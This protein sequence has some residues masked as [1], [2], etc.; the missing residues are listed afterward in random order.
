MKL[1]KLS[2]EEIQKSYGPLTDSSKQGEFVSLSTNT[3]HKCRVHFYLRALKPGFKDDLNRIHTIYTVDTK[4][5]AEIDLTAP[6]IS[7]FITFDNRPDGNIFQF[8]IGEI[9]DFKYDQSKVSSNQSIIIKK[10]I[11]IVDDG[12]AT[13]VTDEVSKHLRL[14]LKQNR[15]DFGLISMITRTTNYNKSNLNIT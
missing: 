13:V 3:W 5:P 12:V 6:T 15:S 2:F 10:H 9:L 11:P 7:P 4:R 8:F 14:L 1:E